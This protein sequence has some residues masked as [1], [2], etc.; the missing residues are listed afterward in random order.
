L[1]AMAVCQATV[2]L[3]VPASSLAG[4]LPQFFVVSLAIADDPIPCRSWL[5]GDDGVSGDSDIECA[6]LFAGRPAPTVI[7][8]SLVLADNHKSV[9]AGLPAMAAY[10][11]ILMLDVPSTLSGFC[12]RPVS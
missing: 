5:A 9:G 12:V 6:G 1:P 11:A 10:Q 2:M 8:V 3:D 7:L 4:Q